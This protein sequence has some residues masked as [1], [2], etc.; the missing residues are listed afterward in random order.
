[1]VGREVEG[2]GRRSGEGRG[3]GE[4]GEVNRRKD[5]VGKER[6]EEG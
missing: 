1:M 3:G 4:E 2:S 6:R 5:G